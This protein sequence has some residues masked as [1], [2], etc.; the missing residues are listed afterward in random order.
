MASKSKNIKG[1]SVEIGGDTTSLQKALKDINC[2]SKATQTELRKI[3]KALKF[4][5]E[6]VVLLTQKQELLTEQVQ[7]TKTKLEQLESIRNQVE[8]QAKESDLGAEQYR[9]YQREIEITKSTL[10]NF[11]KKLSETQTKIQEAETK[12]NSTD[13]QPLQD[14]FSETQR[15]AQTAEQKINSTNLQPLKT[16]FA[17]T[18]KSGKDFAQ[19]L[20]G[21]DLKQFKDKVDDVKKSASNLKSDLKDISK[22][23]CAGIAGAG[24]A[25]AGAV[26]SF[27]SV[28]SALNHIQNQTGLAD[29]AMQEY[30]GTIQSIYKNNYGEDMTD[31]ANVMSAVVQYTKETDPT[32]LQSTVESVFALRD[33]FGF[34]F[35]ETLRTSQMLIKQFGISGEEAFNLI[36]QGAQNGLNKNGDLLDT[37]N[38]YSVHYNQLGYTAEEFFNSLA[39]GTEAGTF[40]VDKLGD[41]MK[42]F[43]IRTK[44]TAS[45]T[46]EAFTLL[47]Y[48]SKASS[49]DIQKTKDEIA[50]L[51]KNLEYAKIEQNNFNDSTSEFTK[52]K[53]ADKIAEYSEQLDNAKNKLAALTD[54]TDGSKKSMEELQAKFAAGGDKAK[55]A[56]Q[57]VLEQLFA[58]D[59]AVLQNQIGVD[60]FGT[61]WEDLGV[62]GVKAL[63]NVSGSA[64]KTVKSMEK[65]KDIEYDDVSNSISGIGRQFQTDVVNKMIKKYYPQIKKGIA[66]TSEHLDDFV[67]IIKGVAKE[68]AVLYAANKANTVAKDVSQ[69][70]SAYKSLRTATDSV[71]TSQKALNFAQNTNAIGILI[72]AVGTLTVAVNEYNQLRWNSSEA[73]KFCDEIDEYANTLND[74]TDRINEN[75][76]SSF[77]SL[78]DIFVNNTLIDDY[79]TELEELLK[80]SELT[81]EETGRLNTIVKYFN[82]NVDGF[83]E[84]L[85]QYVDINGNKVSLINGDYDTVIEKLRDVRDEYKVTVA[86]TALS[87]IIEDSNKNLYSV[88]NDEDVKDALNKIDDA[89]SKF[90]KYK[91]NALNEI[92]DKSFLV[93]DFTEVE[94]QIN[95][96]DKT[97]LYSYVQSGW[98]SQS[99]YDELTNSYDSYSNYQKS[100]DGYLESIQKYTELNKVAQEAQVTLNGNWEDGET[101]L[102]LYNQRMLSAQTVQEK[103]GQSVE[104]LQ[105][106]FGTSN[107]NI[108]SSTSQAFS[109]MKIELAKS[110]DDWDTYKND[111]AFSVGGVDYT[112]QDLANMSLDKFSQMSSYFNTDDWTNWGD[113]AKITSGEVEDGLYNTTESI[114]AELDRFSEHSQQVAGVIGVSTAS[115]G[116]N[117]LSDTLSSEETVKKCLEAAKNLTESVSEGVGDTY[118]EGKSKGVDYGQGYCDGLD[119]KIVD[120]GV[121]AINLINEVT[122]QTQKAQDSHSPSKKSRKFGRDYGQGYYLGIDDE[123]E[124]AV[125]SAES[126][127]DAT[128]SATKTRSEHVISSTQKLARS[129]CDEFNKIDGSKF[130]VG[131][132]LSR[133]NEIATQPKNSMQSMSNIS[134]V[135]NS[136]IINLNFGGVTLANGYDTDQFADDIMSALGAR[137]AIQGMGWG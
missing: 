123:K 116:V 1:I 40:S 95:Q 29:S 41:T 73:K 51:E 99:T 33:T 121:T 89:K 104:Q 67:P 3:D 60:L 76:E 52:Q 53:N 129:M 61:M 55:E 5:P 103:T 16:E 80:K 128:I 82:D 93:S 25:V 26:M 10:A 136:P 23:F 124:N 44:D 13:L 108:S 50:K 22:E 58:I 19:D 66:W 32:K 70:I 7:N 24:T 75:F 105:E 8:S 107:N 37:I 119:S 28:E 49:E 131:Y 34:D 31:I 6:S 74:T 36:V 112:M 125:K 48:S 63:M 114:N 88:L 113:V 97:K 35:S 126:V 27:D 11:E 109:N 21:V 54:N 130:D 30:E 68:A 78:D 96:G 47:G 94:N 42:E 46:V 83:S 101:V 132:S 90:Q 43:G 72:G 39:N 91:N 69:L 20:N 71:K 65:I 98:L 59:D 115:A 18:G 106:K 9:E 57:E 45:S 64:D 4:S 2:S 100:V 122:T 12:I 127:V 85:D 79:G 14:E 133:I 62:D 77:K 87:Q 102:W 118:E 111:V 117:G 86:Q 17:E 92:K 110:K 137:V 135:N 38:E 84:T 120:A 15:K 134:T 56:T 81:P